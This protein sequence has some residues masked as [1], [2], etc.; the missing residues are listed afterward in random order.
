[1]KIDKV[2]ASSVK[3][4]VYQRAFEKSAAELKIVGR[5]SGLV[6]AK[7]M[8]SEAATLRVLLV[9]E[10][11][12]GKTPFAR[13]SSDVVSEL[14]GQVRPFEQLNCACLNTE[15]FQDQLFG[16]K[17]GAFTGAITD[18]RGLVELARGGTCS[19]MKSA[20]CRSKPKRCFSL[21]WIRWNII[22]SATM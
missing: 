15:Q 14:T 8:I 2:F 13:Y 16:H 1:M 21:S 4:R 17:K 12:V 20:K 22:A 18:K 19:W 11:G 6:R 5:D 9:G 7:Q 3:T 10:T